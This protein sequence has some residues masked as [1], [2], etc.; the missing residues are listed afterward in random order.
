M[1]R[2]TLLLVGILAALL[3]PLG[4]GSSDDG[5]KP[6]PNA[7]MS[8]EQ[9]AKKQIEDIQKNPGIPEQAKQAAIAA[10]KANSQPKK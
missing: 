6:D 7:G 2:R 5:L 1:A 4:C 8:A 9:R 10:V 3:A